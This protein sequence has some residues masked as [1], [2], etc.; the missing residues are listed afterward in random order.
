[1]TTGKWITV[2][3]VIVRGH[4]VAARRSAYYPKGTIKLQK[5]FFKQ[6]GLDLSAYKNG[7]LNISI[8]PHVFTMR[9]PEYTFPKVEW[10]SAHPPETFSFSRCSVSFAGIRYEG[11]VYYPH[12]ETKER[13][14]QDPSVVEVITA[15]VPGITYGDAVELYLNADEIT[16]D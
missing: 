13:N 12:P 7:T 3:G 1:M 16:I 14:F 6:R 9:S 10:T 8:S 2:S 15:R 4:R 5:P 11:W